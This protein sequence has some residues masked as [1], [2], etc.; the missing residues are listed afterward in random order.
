MEEERHDSRE[1]TG[2]EGNREVEA[3]LGTFSWSMDLILGTTWST[4][5]SDKGVCV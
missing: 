4:K 2:D 5:A 3:R 1:A